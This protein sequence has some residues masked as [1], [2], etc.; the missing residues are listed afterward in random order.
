MINLIKKLHEKHLFLILIHYKM[1][2]FYIL[3]KIDVITS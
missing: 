2:N 1:L 3:L